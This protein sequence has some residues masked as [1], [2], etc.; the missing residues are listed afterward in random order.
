MNYDSYLQSK[1]WKTFSAAYRKKHKRCCEFCG[2][3][4]RT[5]L[6][7]ITYERLGRERNSDVVLLCEDCHAE[8]HVL[9]K[10]GKARSIRDATNTVRNRKHKREFAVRGRAR[11]QLKDS[12]KRFRQEIIAAFE[13]AIAE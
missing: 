13:H 6:H 9:V 7:H 5:E 11:L 1:H 4:G 3:I 10:N 8:I 12:S 2:S